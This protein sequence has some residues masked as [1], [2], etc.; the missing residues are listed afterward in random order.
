MN[1]KLAEIQSYLLGNKRGITILYVLSAIFIGLNC[2]LIYREIYYLLFLPLFLVI[3]YLYFY[4]RFTGLRTFDA[5]GITP[6]CH[7][8]VLWQ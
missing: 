7:K 4:W 8:N 3:L 2:Y 5:G 6:V 1:N